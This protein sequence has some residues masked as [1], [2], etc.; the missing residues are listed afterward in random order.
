MSRIH[1]RSAFGL[2]LAPKRHMQK[3]QLR[4]T[5]NET[6][7]CVPAQRKPDPHCQSVAA[8]HRAFWAMLSPQEKEN[9][10][11]CLQISLQKGE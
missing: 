3:D 5:N 2:F 9:A 11:Y 6:C 8:H 10:K 1:S 7:K 4:F